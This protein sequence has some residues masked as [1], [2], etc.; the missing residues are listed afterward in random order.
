[1]RSLEVAVLFLIALMI[2]MI[3]VPFASAHEH[4][5]LT[6]GNK[7]VEFVVGW[8]TEPPYVDEL[9]GIDFHARVVS[10]GAPVL[11]LDKVLQVEVSTGNQKV[12]LRLNPVLSDDVPPWFL[13]YTADI[14]PTVAGVYVFRFFGNVNGTQVNESFQCGPSTFECVN[15][16]SDIQFPEK[17]PSGKQTQVAL[18]SMQANLQNVESQLRYALYFAYFLGA[19]G[20]A[21]GIIGLVVFVKTMRREKKAK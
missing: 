13:G 12:T 19:T 3:N 18:Q 8:I 20:I 11:G 1:M 4:R 6:I 7:Q 17:T 10:T 9:N 14:M 16:L 5:T 21:I 2:I 15:S